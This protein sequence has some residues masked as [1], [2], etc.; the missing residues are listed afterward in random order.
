MHNEELCD[1]A[2]GGGLGVGGILGKLL[3]FCF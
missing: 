3:I 1:P 2:G